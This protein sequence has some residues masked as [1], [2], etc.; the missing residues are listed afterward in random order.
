MAHSPG[1]VLLIQYNEKG[2]TY[3]ERLVMMVSMSDPGC[4]ATMTPDRDVYVEDYSKHNANVKKVV[5]VSGMGVIPRGVSAKKIY[6]FADKI[7]TEEEL[8][9]GMRVAAALCGAAVPAVAFWRKQAEPL[10]PARADDRP[11]SPALPLG[12][13]HRDFNPGPI[14]V[15]EPR[16]TLDRGE[17][18]AFK[19]AATPGARYAGAGGVYLLTEPTLSFEIGDAFK[20]PLNAPTIAGS[21][22]FFVEIEGEGVVLQYLGEGSDIT[23]Y[24]SARKSF[25]NVDRR[26]IACPT[27][28]DGRSVAN[29]I[30]D[31]RVAKGGLGSG[32]AAESTAPWFIARVAET[33]S[34]FLQR[35]HTWRHESGVSASMPLVFE[36]E[37]LSTGF[38]LAIG[39]DRLN[40]KNLASFEWFIR[41]MQLHEHAVLENPSAPSY[42]GARH[43]MGK[44]N[45]R[46][47]ALIAPELHAYV[48]SELGK[49]SAILREKR[50][51]REA[52]AAEK[53]GKGKP[54]GPAGGKTGKADG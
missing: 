40:I 22:K 2:A 44:G 47:G 11:A 39:V 5:P 30:G 8:E 15:A 52:R 27:E 14:Q 33:G 10:V 53:G 20:P 9:Q 38:D 32:I 50:K 42:E 41:R 45:R 54:G 46:G 31:M 25:L 49:E 3:H 21:G 7:P 19:D 23:E 17:V 43:F 51:A 16:V 12:D 35:H 4:Y 18:A 26:T 36:H 6:G 13:E 28:D 1:N 29:L 34:G 24:I 48:A 37:M